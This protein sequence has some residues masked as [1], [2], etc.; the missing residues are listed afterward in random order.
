MFFSIG[1]SCV[2]SSAGGPHCWQPTRPLHRS[3]SNL[4]PKFRGKFPEVWRRATQ[5]ILLSLAFLAAAV[6]TRASIPQS[7]KPLSSSQIMELVKAGMGSEELAKH[8]AELGIDFEPSEDYLEALKKAGAGDAV[9]RSLRNGRP[10]PLTREQLL[11]LLAGGV[12]SHR[13]AALVKQHGIDF[14]ID[15]AY[16]QTLRVAGADDEVIAA[17]RAASAAVVADLFVETS[18]HAAVYLDDRLEGQ[19]DDQGGLTVGKVK[20]GA[21]VLKV[22]LAGKREFLQNVSVT[23]AGR[24]DLPAP[25][26]D[27]PGRIVVASST[28]AQFLLDGQSKGQ[29]DAGGKLVV[30][31][32]P[33]RAKRILKAE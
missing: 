31:N 25:L 16:L 24:N 1:A 15:D 20:M 26:V 28:G 2:A 10:K 4:A 11:Q 30:E 19:A 7:D 3:T 22:V 29:T 17:V 33:A 13:A 14:P 5:C 9:I 21:H 23:K 12:P 18:P 6:G 8:I 32:V 27:L